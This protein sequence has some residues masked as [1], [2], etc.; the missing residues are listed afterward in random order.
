[1]TSSNRV[2]LEWR[3]GGGIFIPELAGDL[4]F[5]ARK[6]RGANSTRKA[7]PVAFAK[8][9]NPALGNSGGMRL[10]WACV[11]TRHAQESVDCGY[12]KRTL[13]TCQTAVRRRYQIDENERKRPRGMS[14]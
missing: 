12:P 13:A 6:W 5:D 2:L 1:M 4:A 14:Q 7:Y 9:I 8:R 10:G 11:S 3:E